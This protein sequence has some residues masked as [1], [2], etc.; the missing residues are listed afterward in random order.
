MPCSPARKVHATS[1]QRRIPSSLR[2]SPSL[3]PSPPALFRGEKIPECKCCPQL[4]TYQTNPNDHGFNSSLRC[5]L[6]CLISIAR[7]EGLRMMR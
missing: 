2:S 7:V 6:L 5:S 4:Q 1:L 3:P